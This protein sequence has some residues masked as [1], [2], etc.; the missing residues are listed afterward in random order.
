MELIKIYQGN[1]IN[2]RELHKFLD[3]KQIFGNW[4]VNRIK[5]YKFIEGKSYIIKLLNRV[6]GKAGKPKKE[7]YLTLDMAKELAMV[8]NNSKGREARLYFIEAEKTLQGL[9]KNKRLEAFMKLEATK[10]ALKKHV[11]QLGGTDSNYI[12]IDTAGS[13]VLFNG[14]E[15][16][17]EELPT[18]LL[19]GRGLATEMTNE[20]IKNSV[21]S[22]EEIEEINKQRH[23]D[24]K[25]TIVK[26]TGL[27][28]EYFPKEKSINDI[29]RNKS[30]E[31]ILPD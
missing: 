7:Y 12:Q 28:P 8:E 25:D 20:V 27:R 1:L 21:F 3:S 9:K 26:G 4:I 18:L 19:M 17:D 5:K 30:D 15:I 13:K 10:G 24:V 22:M 16:E 2:A 23:S 6:D 14:K 29:D 11:I 31:N